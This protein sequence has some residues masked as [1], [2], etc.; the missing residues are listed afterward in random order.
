MASDFIAIDGSY[1]NVFDNE[2]FHTWRN[3]DAIH[4]DNTELPLARLKYEIVSIGD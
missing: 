3:S 4:V 2:G 1:I